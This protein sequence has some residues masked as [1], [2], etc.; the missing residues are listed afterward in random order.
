MAEELN[1][2]GDPLV[3]EI[4]DYQIEGFNY[5]L[6]SW[7]SNRLGWNVSI[8]DTDNVAILTGINLISEFSNLTWKYSRKTHD[9]FEGDLFL[10]N[11]QDNYDTP[12]TS[13][14]FGQDNEWGLFYLTNSDQVDLG[15]NK[16]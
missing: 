11:K 3:V 2:E 14:N 10:I 7:Y 9:L 13:D 4:K 1:I 5:R 15:I 6:H 12:L 8:Y 16:R